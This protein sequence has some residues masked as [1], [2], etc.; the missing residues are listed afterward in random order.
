MWSGD[1]PMKNPTLQE[2]DF[3][4]VQL[5]KL[6]VLNFCLCSKLCALKNI[7]LHVFVFLSLNLKKDF[8]RGSFYVC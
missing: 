6:D 8:T 4:F 5:L 1:G 2:C 3:K 7:F